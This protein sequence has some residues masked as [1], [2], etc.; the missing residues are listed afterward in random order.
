MG[1]FVHPTFGLLGL[2]TIPAR[3]PFKESLGFLTDISPAYD[4]GEGRIRLRSKPRQRLG[5]EFTAQ[6]ADSKAVFNTVY[7]GMAR[8]WGVPVWPLGRACGTV[9]E[10]QTVIDVATLFSDYRVGGPVLVLG[11][12]GEWFVGYISEMTDSTVTLV[13]PAPMPVRGAYLVPV[14]VGRI[15]SSG[16]KDT[17]G[18]GADWDITFEV[19]DNLDWQPAEPTQY[20]GDDIYL[21]PGLLEGDSLGERVFT[22]LE[23]FDFDLGPVTAFTPWVNNRTSRPYR[24]I[25]ETDAEAWALRGWLHR[26]AGRYRPFWQPSFENDV[27][28]AQTGALASTVTVY[29]DERSPWAS[30]RLNLAFGLRDGTWLPRR[31]T[32]DNIVDATARQLGLNSALGVNASEVVAISYMGLKRLEGDTVELNWLGNG[33]CE[34]SASVVELSP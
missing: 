24:V 19:D 16:Q 23:T 21:T 9:L 12:C 15:V 3:A 30:N 13:D 31:V 17:D 32:S 4:G 10:T 11:V 33:R 27:R 28:L 5:M 7:G 1:S 34:M 2:L 20:F 26:R 29:A 8:R 18:Y 6:P 25:T 22:Q 14:R